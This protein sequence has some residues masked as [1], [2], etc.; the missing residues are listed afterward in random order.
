MLI[1]DELDASPERPVSPG[2]RLRGTNF[3]DVKAFTKE[4]TKLGVKKTI[5]NHQPPWAALR[6]FESWA[7]SEEARA[8]QMTP[9]ERQA[10]VDLSERIPED[11][12]ET[13]EMLWKDWLAV[14]AHWMTVHY[15][16]L[17]ARPADV[18]RQEEPTYP[19]YR[20]ETCE[21][22]CLPWPNE[23][24]A[25]QLSSQARTLVASSLAIGRH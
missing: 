18:V 17:Q 25:N 11:Q 13:D 10:L 2:Q 12:K 20:F 5:T 16:Y 1:P 23:D 9:E 14:W 7:L 22:Q 8:N 24:R 19:G 21:C 15:Q 6:S 4:L 3:H